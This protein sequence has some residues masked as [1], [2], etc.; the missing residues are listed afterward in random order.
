MNFRHLLGCD[1]IVA[2]FELINWKFFSRIISI[3]KNN[4]VYTVIFEHVCTTGKEDDP[5]QN[6]FV[7]ASY[8]PKLQLNP[9]QGEGLC[10]QVSASWKQ[11]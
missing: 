3:N 11:T 6:V 4:S 2:D 5:Y 1:T 8:P 10:D 9:S 7:S